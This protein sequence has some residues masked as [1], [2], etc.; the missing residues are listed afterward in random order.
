[1]WTALNLTQWEPSFLHSSLKRQKGKDG[2]DYLHS[3]GENAQGD[4]FMATRFLFDIIERCG[5]QVAVILWNKL[6]KVRG[7]VT[8]AK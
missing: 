2:P 6:T 4:D 7:G 5:H 8:F 1:M 3:S